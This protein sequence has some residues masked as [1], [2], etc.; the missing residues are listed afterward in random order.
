MKRVV[1]SA[2]IRNQTRARGLPAKGGVGWGGGGDNHQ[3]LRSELLLLPADRLP[4]WQQEGD[5]GRERHGGAAV[6]YRQLSCSVN[7]GLLESS[8]TPPTPHPSHCPPRPHPPK[9]KRQQL[10]PSSSEVW[11]STVPKRR[12]DE[13]SPQLF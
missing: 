12:R 7:A 1:C 10:R 2:H 5:G 11:T 13:R 4:L 6:T 8:N 9:K 3:L